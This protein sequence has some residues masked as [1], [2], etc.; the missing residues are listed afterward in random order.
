[1]RIPRKDENVPIWEKAYLT[2]AE[3]AEYTGIGVNKLRALSD[4][5]YC[6]YVLWVGNRRM[7]NRKK[8]EEYLDTQKSI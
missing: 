7:L 5:E 4:Q 1:M 6:N 8:L 2:L 3:A